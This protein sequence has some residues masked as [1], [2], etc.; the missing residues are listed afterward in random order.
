MQ[1][2][3]VIQENYRQTYIDPIHWDFSFYFFIVTNNH[4]M[5]LKNSFHEWFLYKNCIVQQKLRRYFWI[6]VDQWDY[7]EY[8]GNER[9]EETYIMSHNLSWSSHCLSV[10]TYFLLLTVPVI[11]TPCCRIIFT[12]SKG[13]WK[14]ET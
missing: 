8:S 3:R 6:N 1:M 4:N 5:L 13:K 11:M 12:W 14:Y 9:I 10:L 7:D 2:H